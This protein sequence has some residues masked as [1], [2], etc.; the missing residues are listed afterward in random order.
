M[1]QAVALHPDFFHLKAEAGCCP[2]LPS[3]G[4]VICYRQCWDSPDKPQGHIHNCLQ[5]WESLYTF[6]PYVEQTH[7]CPDSFTSWPWLDH[8]W[9]SYTNCSLEGLLSSLGLG[10][11]DE[12]C[13]CNTE[14]VRETPNSAPWACVSA[15]PTCRG[16]CQGRSP[17]GFSL[18]ASWRQVSNVFV[19]YRAGSSCR[20]RDWRK[21]T[22][23]FSK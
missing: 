13:C 3:E 16:G 17:K 18:L 2:P 6:L 11:L 4:R 5:H 20:G 10:D 23:L 15:G 21:K 19:V 12:Q 7:C 22:S 8:W 1:Y 9:L 14:M